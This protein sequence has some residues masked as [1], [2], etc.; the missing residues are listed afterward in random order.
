[1]HRKATLGSQSRHGR[2]AQH[3]RCYACR[4]FSR[5]TLRHLHQANEMLGPTLTT[6][7]NLHFFA[8]FMAAIRKAIGEGDLESRC[9][10][11]LGMMYD[12]N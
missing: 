5:G 11:W 10:Q 9:R 6:I 7:H 4:N 8:Q 12:E 1:M 3:C 2:L